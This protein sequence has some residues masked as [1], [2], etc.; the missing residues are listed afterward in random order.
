MPVE[1]VTQEEVADLQGN[2]SYRYQ[3]TVSLPEQGFVGVV[4]VDGGPG[5]ADRAIEAA[6]ELAGDVQRVA[7]TPL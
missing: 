1:S 7:A 3:V 5:W 4:T 2:I 6:R